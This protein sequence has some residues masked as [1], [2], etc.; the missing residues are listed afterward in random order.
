MV[1]LLT[2]KDSFVNLII[3]TTQVFWILHMPD[4]LLF[5]TMGFKF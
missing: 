2:Y 3:V 4:S 5:K 1:I